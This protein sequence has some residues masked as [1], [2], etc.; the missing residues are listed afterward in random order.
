M[1]HD[2]LKLK[3]IHLPA[4]TDLCVFQ[5][6]EL[7]TIARF[8]MLLRSTSCVIKDFHRARTQRGT[9]TSQEAYQTQQLPVLLSFVLTTELGALTIDTQLQRQLILLI[10]H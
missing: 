1:H 5:A 6:K 7:I 8:Q 3:S 2:N 10:L 9:Q 4:Y